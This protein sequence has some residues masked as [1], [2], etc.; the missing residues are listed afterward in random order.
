M[1]IAEN[2]HQK[3]SLIGSFL[4]ITF[5]LMLTGWGSC[6][7]L[8][9]VLDW[10]VNH[11]VIRVLFVVGGFSPTVASFW[12]MRKQQLVI[13]FRDWIK[14]VFDVNH[15]LFTYGCVFF[16]LQSTIFLAVQSMDSSWVLLSLCCL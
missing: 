13:N 11:P 16:L 8:S 4:A 15:G 9:Q 12:A 6:A 1:K 5:G 3:S 10:T 7:V 2:R 14:Q